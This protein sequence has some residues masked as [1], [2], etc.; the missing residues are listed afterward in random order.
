MSVKR[1]NRQ[2]ATLHAAT[3]Q[4]TALTGQRPRVIDEP[5]AVRIEADVTED[6]LTRH[7]PRLHAVLDLGAGFGLRTTATGHTAWLRLDRGE[8]TRP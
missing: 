2:T 8:N 6:L 1:D 7:W 5:G 3:T 4:L